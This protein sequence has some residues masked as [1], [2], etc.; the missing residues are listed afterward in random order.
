MSAVLNSIAQI[1]KKPTE[2]GHE[3]LG[4]ENMGGTSVALNQLQENTTE[5]DSNIVAKNTNL[6]LG[7]AQRGAERGSFVIQNGYGLESEEVPEYTPTPIETLEQRKNA[8]VDKKEKSKEL[9]IQKDEG[10]G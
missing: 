3:G 10:K 8:H 9:T 7:T 5:N 1:V 4:D 2:T 6:D